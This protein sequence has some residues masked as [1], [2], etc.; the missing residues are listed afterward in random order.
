[1]ESR[2]S[3]SNGSLGCLIASSASSARW[4]FV[5]AFAAIL[6]FSAPLSLVSSFSKAHSSGKA[7]HTSI[8]KVKA[9]STTCERFALRRRATSGRVTVRTEPVPISSPTHD[10]DRQAAFRPLRC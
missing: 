7:P 3:T 4:V 10:D 5:A 9:V 6:V 8:S 2:G 1:M